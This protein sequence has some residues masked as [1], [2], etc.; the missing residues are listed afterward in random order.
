MAKRVNNYEAKQYVNRLQEFRGSHLFACNEG[1]LY[2]V[3][4][5]GNHWP[6]YAYDRA[7]SQWYGNRNKYSSSTSRHATR[8]RPSSKDIRWLNVDEML[9]IIRA[10]GAGRWVMQRMT[11][12]RNLAA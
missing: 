2:V 3:Y 9:E 8:T 6:L 10:G 4:S 1:D 11:A 12:N 5:Y 7:G